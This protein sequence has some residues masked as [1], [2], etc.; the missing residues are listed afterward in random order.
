[1]GVRVSDG[2]DGAI[3]AV[4]AVGRELGGSSNK[5]RDSS[6]VGG[7]ARPRTWPRRPVGRGFYGVWRAGGERF[8]T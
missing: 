4:G 3:E 8:P 5:A 6:K 7:D 1:V 2:A